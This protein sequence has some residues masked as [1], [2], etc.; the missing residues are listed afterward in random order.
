MKKFFKKGS[1]KREKRQSETKK[2]ATRK[3]TTR[4]R[5]V[6]KNLRNTM[7]APQN[8]SSIAF[9]GPESRCDFVGH[10]GEFKC[11][12]C[13]FPDCLHEVLQGTYK[14]SQGEING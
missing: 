1:A 8:P 5:G 10:I 4:T 6:T 11:L 13:P 3:M 14:I 12:D 9:R 2:G 7:S